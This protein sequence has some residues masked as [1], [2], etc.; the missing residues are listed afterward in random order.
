MASPWG[1][2]G[3][4]LHLPELPEGKPGSGTASR[5]PTACVVAAAAALRRPLAEAAGA[6]TAWEV[7]RSAN[8]PFPPRHSLLVFSLTSG[9]S[10]EVST[11][12]FFVGVDVCRKCD[13]WMELPM[14]CSPKA[15]KPLRLGIAPAS[16]GS[17]RNYF[18]FF[19][20]MSSQ[21]KF[22]VLS[23]VLC[24]GISQIFILAYPWPWQ[25]QLFQKMVKQGSVD[26]SVC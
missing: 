5:A 6:D 16:F 8:S 9:D 18:F 12:G 11:G 25:E 1:D 4:R 2:H 14:L 19:F 13:A 3:T 17:R 26:F 20:L 10:H 7:P 15:T 24:R 22:S 23:L 21:E